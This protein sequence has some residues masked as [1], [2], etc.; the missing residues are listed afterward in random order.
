MQKLIQSLVIALTL[1]A[2]ATAANAET[3]IAVLDVQNAIL[4]TNQ[5]QQALSDLREQGS[6]KE[7]MKQLEGLRKEHDDLIAKLKKDMAVMSD[8]QKQEKAKQIEEKR[9]DIQHVGRKLQAAEQ[10]LAQELMQRMAQQVQT[11]VRDIIEQEKIGLLIDRKAVLHVEPS[12]SIT[13]KVTEKL[14]AQ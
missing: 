12:Y 2:S 9:A 4:N 13:A 8:E 7:N 5:A 10:E 1:V 11:A 3:K 6:Y 14:N